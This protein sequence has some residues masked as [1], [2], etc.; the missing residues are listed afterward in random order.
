[1][2]EDGYNNTKSEVGTHFLTPVDL[3]VEAREKFNLP[4]E[5]W[6]YPMLQFGHPRDLYY[7]EIWTDGMDWTKNVWVVRTLRH[8][9]P[10]VVPLAF[11]EDLEA[12]DKFNLY[13]YQNFLKA[14]LEVE[15]DRVWVKS[16]DVRD[17][18]VWP[19]V[20][21]RSGDKGPAGMIEVRF[22]HASQPAVDFCMNMDFYP[23]LHG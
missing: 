11:F 4:S 16:G 14:C 3:I 21:V 15:R 18:E 6:A 13:D 20:K 23:G 5:N 17:E 8:D 1:M 19:Y 22:E 10:T 9:F 2:K 12:S 7:A